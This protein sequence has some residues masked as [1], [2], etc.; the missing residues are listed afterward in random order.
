MTTTSKNLIPADRRL[1]ML[2]G[3]LEGGSNYWYFIGE[4]AYE[5]IEKHLPGFSLRHDVKSKFYDIPFV[6]LM[7]RAV[8]LG[9]SIPIRDAEDHDSILG[10]FSL[11]NIEAREPL[12]YVHHTNFYL[13]IINEDD[14][15]ETADIWFQYC[16]LGEVIYG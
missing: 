3:A 4:D 9:A 13:D 10:Y 15:A 1:D 16:V 5:E 2:T 7:W 12:L 11:E 6:D 14:D 8:S